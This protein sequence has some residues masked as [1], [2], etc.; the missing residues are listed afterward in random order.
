MMLLIAG[1][2]ALFVT[3]GLRSSRF[4]YLEKEPIDTLYGVDGMVRER[5]EQYRSAYSLQ[6]V[7]GIILCVLSVI[8]L[9]IAVLF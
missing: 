6:L 2:V 1:A 7:I 8:P 5:R 4:D 3:S 9:G